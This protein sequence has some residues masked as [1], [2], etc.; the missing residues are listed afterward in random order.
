MFIE[1]LNSFKFCVESHRG[2]KQPGVYNVEYSPPWWGGGIKSNGLEMGKII[3][4]LKIRKKKIFEDLTLLA[5]P[6]CKM[7]RRQR[8]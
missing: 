2:Q 1:H 8:N 3:K 4:S 5:V 6:K 7:Y